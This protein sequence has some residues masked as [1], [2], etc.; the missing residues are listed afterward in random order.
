MSDDPAPGRETR[1]PGQAPV[2]PSVGAAASGSLVG[3]GSVVLGSL[4]MRAC[5]S[6]GDSPSCGGPG[7]LLLVGIVVALVVL[8][9][10]LLAYVN[11]PQPAL[12]S[13]LGVTLA[14][15]TVLFGLVEGTSSVWKWLAMPLLG[16]GSF[17]LSH[18]VLS[19]AAKPEPDDC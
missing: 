13:L 8:G 18:L 5:D 10:V 3:F 1:S 12:V 16:A 11:V 15:V 14:G 2:S 19:T 7:L 4:G 6:L 17:A 9:S